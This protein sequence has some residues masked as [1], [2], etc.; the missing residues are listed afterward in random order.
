MN[1][2][3]IDALIA[4]LRLLHPEL[5]QPLTWETMSLILR[6]E[7]IALLKLPLQ[8]DAQVI[9]CDGVSVIAINSN[10]SV[11]RHTYFA[12]HEWGHI[13]LHFREPG[14]I[15][16]HT[17]A[18]WPDDPREDQA[19]YFATTLL[20][21]PVAPLGDAPEGSVVRRND[22]AVEPPAEYRRRRR[23][24]PKTPPAAQTTLPLPPDPVPYYVIMPEPPN[25]RSD[26]V[27]HL[28][29]VYSPRLRAQLADQER[30]EAV[31]RAQQLDLRP[32]V[33]VV[34]DGRERKHYLIDRD[35]RRWRVYDMVPP[36]QRSSRSKPTATEPP[37]NWA[38]SRNFVAED[39]VRR[40]YQ[41]KFREERAMN[42]LQ[43]ER[44]LQSAE[45][46]APVR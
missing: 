36:R 21:G 1:Q 9:S 46:S 5:Q 35:G 25:D 30:V 45:V 31:A 19:E 38:E 14:E 7:R 42:P 40:Q 8:H 23:R 34:I 12:A 24:L 37:N 29:R 43:L 4:D 18:C 44:Q 17:S 6:R 33:E 41:F 28:V 39:G 11:R 20:L 16:Y 26:A 27:T 13:K 3:A 22:G 15:V 32:R 2:S 10:A